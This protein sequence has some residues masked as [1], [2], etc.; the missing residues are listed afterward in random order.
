MDGIRANLQGEVDTI[1][2]SFLDRAAAIDALSKASCGEADLAAV[3]TK[4]A[5]VANAAIAAGAAPVNKEVQATIALVRNELAAAVSALGKLE[6]FIALSTPVIEDGGNFGVSVQAEVKK[7]LS[8]YRAALKASM[9]AYAEC[10]FF[11]RARAF[12]VRVARARAR[13][14]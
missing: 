14:D 3:E 11:A 8:E 10:V 2:G 13:F 5:A 4:Y 7:N 9:G 6:L 1:L 12:C